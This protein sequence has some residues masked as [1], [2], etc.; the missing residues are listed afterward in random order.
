MDPKLVTQVT[1]ELASLFIGENLKAREKMASGTKEFVE[2]QLEET[3]KK[4]EAQDAKIREYRQ[5]YMGELPE[6]QA[7]TLQ[8]MGQLQERFRS[9]NEALERAAQQKN[10]WEMMLAS[11]NG[12]ADTDTEKQS[13]E[14]ATKEEPAK[15]L[16]PIQNTPEPSPEEVQLTVLL[17]RY[18]ER[19]PDVVHLKS[20][21]EATRQ[22]RTARALEPKQATASR[23]VH[24]GVADAEPKASTATA[25]RNSVSSAEAQISAIAQEIAQ[26]KE[27]NQRLTERIASYQAKLEVMPARGQELADLQ[28]EYGIAK[29]YY[30]QFLAR[31]LTAETGAE[32]ELRQLGE[33]FS[34]LEPAHIPERPYRPNRRMHYAASAMGGLVLGFAVALVTELLGITIVSAEQVAIATGMTVLG[35]IPVLRTRTDKRRRRWLIAGSVTAAVMLLLG[36]AFLFYR[37][38]GRI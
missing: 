16:E 15:S 38:Q 36:G 18:G 29:E 32:L 23:P 22:V 30:T 26:R 14:K 12:S 28:R 37:F 13:V 24:D 34:I 20:Q 33:Q 17:A 21:I 19:H 7:T 6:Q 27:E 10:Y 25:K 4:L 35:F 31:R 8:I 2:S 11:N 9:N 1:N 5:K 3:S